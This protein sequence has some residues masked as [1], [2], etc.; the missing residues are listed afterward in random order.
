MK[1]YF[2]SKKIKI[3][4]LLI[5]CVSC[6]IVGAVESNKLSAFEST[7][8][9]NYSGYLYATG[10]DYDK[11]NANNSFL[12]NANSV[13][14]RRGAK[15]FLIDSIADLG[16]D[17]NTIT[18]VDN[19]FFE[20]QV[21]V[22]GFYTCKVTFL[23]GKSVD[24]EVKMTGYSEPA[25]LD[26]SKPS[27]ID[28]CTTSNANLTSENGKLKMICTNPA[29]DDGF[30]LYF[31]T[32]SMT[33]ETFYAENYR[34]FKVK[35]KTS[36]EILKPEFQ[37]YTWSD[38]SANPNHRIDFASVNNGSKEGHD[39]TLIIDLYVNDFTSP[40]ITIYDETN[41]TVSYGKIEGIAGEYSGYIETVRFNFARNSNVQRSALV[42]YIGFF[43]TFESAK[44][45]TPIT[46]SFDDYAKTL[47]TTEFNCLWGDAENEEKAKATVE[48]LI[49]NKYGLSCSVLKVTTWIPSTTESK[50]KLVFDGVFKNNGK[51]EIVSGMTLIINEKPNDYKIIDVSDEN[52]VEKLSFANVDRQILSDDYL[53]NVLYM[54]SN[55][56]AEQDGFYFH[57]G[58]GDYEG[59]DGFGSQTI[60]SSF[61]LQ[62][63][64]YV[65]FRY[66]RVGIGGGQLFF[67]TEDLVGDVPYLELYF[68]KNN[69][70]YY[71]SILCTNVKDYD[72]PVIYNYD[73]TTGEVE[74][75]LQLSSYGLNKSVFKGK[76]TNIRFNFAR[77]AYL[78]REA[79]ID[80]IGFF[81]T[82]D[83]AK[84]YFAGLALKN[85]SADTLE[86][87]EGNTEEVANRSIENII[88]E[89]VGGG[90]KVEIKKISYFA[91]VL[92]ISNGQ[93]KIKADL[94]IGNEVLFTTNEITYTIKNTKNGEKRDY[95]FS[96]PYFI[97]E[98]FGANTK[99][100]D[101]TKMVITDVMPKFTYTVKNNYF[102]VEEKP[103]AAVKINATAND[104]TFTVNNSQY[105]Y[106]SA[107]NGDNIFVYDLLNGDIYNG[108]V[109]VQSVAVND[110]YG[111]VLN[112]GLSFNTLE[113]VS[114]YGVS[115]FSTLDE[116]NAYVG[117][118]VDSS[119][120]NFASGLQEQVAAQGSITAVNEISANK[121]VQNIL[122]RL[123][124][125]TY[126]LYNVETVSFTAPTTEN[127]GSITVNA[128]IYSGEKY[129]SLFKQI[130]LYFNINTL[131][132]NANNG[133]SV[134]EGG[135][136]D[137]TDTTNENNVKWYTNAE[138]G[139]VFNK[140]DGVAV[141]KAISTPTTIEWWMKTESTSGTYTIL[142]NGSTFIVAVVDG[143][144]RYKNNTIEFTTNGVD[145]CGNTMKHFAVVIDND[146]A[147]L[148]ING[149]LVNSY[150]ISGAVVDSTK[151]YIGC[152]NISGNT[153]KNGFF[154]EI[155]DIRIWNVARSTTAISD[156]KD[157]VLAGNEAGLVGYWKLDQQF[158]LNDL[159]ENFIVGTTNNNIYP[160]A[161]EY[162][163]NCMGYKDFTSNNNHGVFFSSGWYNLE[164]IITDYTIIQISD[165][166][167]YMFG[168][169]EYLNDMYSWMNESKK[170]LNI[171]MVN[172]LGDVCQDST[173][174]Q[175]NFT[176][177]AF[178]KYLNNSIPFNIALGNHDYFSPYTG[179]GSEFRDIEYFAEKFSI[180]VVRE[181]FNN[182]DWARYGG[183]FDNYNADN[184]YMFLEAGT[185]TVKY[186]VIILEYGPRQEVINW[187]SELVEKY[188]DHKVIILTHCYYDTFGT[189]STF[190]ARRTTSF[191]DSFEGT[192]I[193][194]EFIDKY[195][196][197]V[198]INCGH[199]QNNQVQAY[200]NTTSKGTQVV[201]ILSDPSAM[202]SGF[203]SDKGIIELMCFTND[204][205]MHT[206]YYS[207]VEK[208][209]CQTQF[210]CT[211]NMADA[212]GLA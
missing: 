30:F 185:P 177:D 40:A 194:N 119:L 156:N 198:M 62:D 108:G 95:V 46:S 19:A 77:K 127:Q 117:E 75:V 22:D 176:Y 54:E 6:I 145:I 104:F 112:F 24:C 53:G 43:S 150:D 18:V 204:G 161:E 2:L 92:N 91:P 13:N 89:K 154:G 69:N 50:G 11:L 169:P 90:L 10:N 197:I 97:R 45:Y 105:K 133:Q 188:S 14:D 132:A 94:K 207:P 123:V 187:A 44:N 167:S 129:S 202:L 157:N 172:H 184:L 181:Q 32:A 212:L 26:F 199:S 140:N 98:I 5:L 76:V 1:R 47:S 64:S 195:D 186:M 166:Q 36:C 192:D 149:S 158:Y 136:L 148:Y 27:A 57:A 142:S 113:E 155:A 96:N 122:I 35:Y 170:D 106:C 153:V 147:V 48:S 56:P 165:T 196:N 125:T 173:A 118:F 16:I 41:G 55:D 159:S 137:I 179:I 107:I 61:Y 42:D 82:F 28:S 110:L 111:K 135:V 38:K 8:T 99:S 49:G 139:H 210:E 160:E 116:A 191:A 182:I 34:Y 51:T 144:L 130:E 205:K 121:K 131:S 68:G 143:N 114:V 85:Y 141:T 9:A 163:Q 84:E 211:F 180:D 29:Y 31:H 120:D 126:T 65:V 109:K 73:E 25:V 58:F 175:W 115:F 152:E 93:Y 70:H 7:N 74:S 203:P 78:E 88:E 128:I 60:S 83:E 174:L 208:M 71:T 183:S 3:L 20:P 17:T 190:N 189:R 15:Q 87:F 79:W 101:Y 21:G 81:P 102:F 178:L 134:V 67:W 151:L 66:K 168:H 171:V 206:Y 86:Y 37:L 52:L 59:I 4:S 63:Y 209:F 100:V 124:G 72:N 12:T 164:N 103:F 201:Q 193:W 200:V 80:Y 39:I 138:K 146:K 162:Y 23:S 33:D